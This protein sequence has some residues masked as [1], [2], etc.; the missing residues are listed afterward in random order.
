VRSRGRQSHK[1]PRNPSRKDRNARVA[2]CDYYARVGA[3]PH[4][5]WLRQSATANVSDSHRRLGAADD[6]TAG[7]IIPASALS[8]FGAPLRMIPLTVMSCREPQVYCALKEN[9]WEEA[10]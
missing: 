5:Q 10:S 4:E 9:T 7:N 1:V 6:L 3:G 8:H 2:V